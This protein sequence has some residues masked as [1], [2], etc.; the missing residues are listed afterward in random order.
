VERIFTA[1]A[2]RRQRREELGFVRVGVLRRDS[3][4]FLSCIERACIERID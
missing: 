4:E 2:L 1:T 3:L